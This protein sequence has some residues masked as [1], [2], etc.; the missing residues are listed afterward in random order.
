LL[1]DKKEEMVIQNEVIKSTTK[2]D[3]YFDDGKNGQAQKP[4]EKNEAQFDNK[5]Q[6]PSQ[7]PTLIPEEL[8]AKPKLPLDDEDDVNFI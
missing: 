7:M 5:V 2:F 3:S 8:P 6:A 1:S 4:P